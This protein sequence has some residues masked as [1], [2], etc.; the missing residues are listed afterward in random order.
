MRIKRLQHRSGGASLE[1]VVYIGAPSLSRSIPGNQHG[2]FVV[3]AEID[4]PRPRAVVDRVHLDNVKASMGAVDHVPVHIRS[5]RPRFGK[6]ELDMRIPMLTARCPPS[7]LPIIKGGWMYEAI[8]SLKVSMRKKSAPG[9]RITRTYCL[10][11]Y[12]VEV[13]IG[14]SRVLRLVL[15]IQR[16]ISTAGRIN[17]LRNKA[18]R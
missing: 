11:I 15:H 4:L 2:E 17:L 8:D 10:N 9:G 13:S 14:R 5:I 3:L 1:F 18:A 16:K 12:R 6:V 7:R